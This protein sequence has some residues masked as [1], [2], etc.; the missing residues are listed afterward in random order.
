MNQIAHNGKFDPIQLQTNS[1]L[2]QFYFHF[3]TV[4]MYQK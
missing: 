2:T 4:L 1:R 3:N